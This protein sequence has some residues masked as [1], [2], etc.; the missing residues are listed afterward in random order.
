MGRAFLPN[1]EVV[2]ISG[3]MGSGKT[4]YA[5]KAI[6]D[7]CM[8]GR[9][10]F[11]NIDIKFPAMWAYCD[12]YGADIKQE[13]ITQLD[14]EDTKNLENVLAKGQRDC[15]VLCVIDE[16]VRSFDPT[17]STS[18]K[19]TAELY[20]LVR[21]VTQQ[22]HWHISFMFIVQDSGQM[23]KRLRVLCHKELKI[24]NWQQ[25]PLPLGLKC[26]IPAYRVSV[27]VQDNPKPSDRWSSFWDKAIWACYDTHEKFDS[28]GLGDAKV[29]FDVKRGGGEEMKLVHK[30][31]LGGCVFVT[32]VSLWKLH[33]VESYLDEIT[34]TKKSGVLF[35]KK[36]ERRLK[37]PKNDHQ[38]EEGTDV[39]PTNS[40]NAPSPSGRKT[41]DGYTTD[42]KFVKFRA[43][44]E[45]RIYCQGR[46]YKRGDLRPEGLVVALNQDRIL[47]RDQDRLV[48]IVDDPSG[49]HVA[50]RSPRR[51]DR[52][53][54][55]RSMFSTSTPY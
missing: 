41:P 2:M 28:F 11:T 37:I 43:K 1:N 44:E 26:P 50:S 5:V 54:V 40:T 12:K 15:P 47:C 38:G 14:L 16:G 46:W 34:Y 7:N 48:L 39:L 33:Q 17:E 3:I 8:A 49:T 42:V 18:E 9:K 29:Q 51:E 45:H 35:F 13:Q 21:L 4:C 55:E 53:D 24:Q 22:R 52:A 36:V 30:V 10:C 25:I 6:A 19:K 32:M 31:A 27:H 20:D 23:I